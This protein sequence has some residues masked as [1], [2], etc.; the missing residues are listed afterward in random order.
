M[1]ASQKTGIGMIVAA[2]IS[3]VLAIFVFNGQAEPAW[4]KTVLNILPTVFGI[5]GISVNLPANT[6][7]S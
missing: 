3:V 1:N 2:V 7:K 5:F 6:N 4:L